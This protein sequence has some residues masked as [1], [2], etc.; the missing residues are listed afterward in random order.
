MLCKRHV[1]WVRREPSYGPH[2]GCLTSYMN[3]LS[4]WK[5]EHIGVLYQFRIGD[6]ELHTGPFDNSVIFAKLVKGD[7]ICA[8][9][10]EVKRLLGFSE[11]VYVTLITPHGLG[12]FEL[13][14]RDV[15]VLKS[16]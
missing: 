13:E 15:V 3:H 2:D 11:S 5:K 8:I 9:D 14:N 7:V 6:V 10:I 12:W 4:E 1:G 16:L